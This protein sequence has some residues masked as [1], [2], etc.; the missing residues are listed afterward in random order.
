MSRD[1]ASNAESSRRWR[2]NHPDYYNRA[3]KKK[4]DPTPQ[5]RRREKLRQR[6][7]TTPEIVDAMAVAQDGRCAICGRV[8]TPL[9]VDHD[10]ATMRVRALLC[11]RCNRG[12]GS[13]LDDPDLLTKAASYLRY[14]ME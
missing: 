5:E 9:H 3:Y 7:G 6:Y 14:W 8:E 13:F 1:A 4:Y 11:G 10:H 2:A 12:L